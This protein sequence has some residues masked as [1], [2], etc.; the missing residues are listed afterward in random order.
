MSDNAA[1]LS[2]WLTKLMDASDDRATAIEDGYIQLERAGLLSKV[3]LHRY[4][5]SRPKACQIARVVKLGDLIL[6]A[7]RDYKYSPGMNLAE[8]VQSA[9]ERNTLNGNNH[10]PGHVYDVAE[11]A[12]W[13]DAA[14]ISMVCRH[15]HGTVL[16]KDMLTLV[17]SVRPGYPGKPTRL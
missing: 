5:C 2:I 13:G 11:L 6:C 16:A 12:T 14:G 10:W 1:D 7:V 15:F 8:S 4:Q 3:T 9:R 17:S